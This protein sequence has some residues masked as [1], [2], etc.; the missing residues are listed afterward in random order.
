MLEG[1]ESANAYTRRVA[2][3]RPTAT[4][5]RPPSPTRSAPRTT[6][7]EGVEY[8]ES[9]KPL[10]DAAAAARAEDPA[11]AVLRQHDA[12]ADRRGARHLADARVPAARPDARAAARAACSPRTSSA[13]GV[14][15]SAARL[16]GALRGRER[17]ARDRGRTAG[18]G[19]VTA[20][21]R[22]G[23]PIRA[24]RWCWTASADRQG[25]EQHRDH[26]RAAPAGSRARSARGQ[27]EQGAAE[28]RRSA[29]PSAM[30]TLPASAAAVQHDAT[31]ARH[32]QRDALDA[33]SA[34]AAAGAR[35]RS[36]HRPPRRPTLPGDP[37]VTRGRRTG[38]SVRAPDVRALLVVNPK[39]TTT[40]PRGSRRPRCGRSPASSSV[41]VVETSHRGH[42]AELAVRAVR[43][44]LDVVVALGGDGTVNEVVNGLLDRRPAGGRCRRWRSCPAVD[45]RLRPRA[46]AAD[47]PGRRDR[48]DPR[49][50]ARPGPQADRAR[51][52]PTTATSRSTPASASTPRWC[53]GSR[54][55]AG[56]AR[57]TRTRCS[58]GPRSPSTLTA[59][60]AR[61]RRSPLRAAGRGADATATSSWCHEH[62]PWSYL[63][64]DRSSRAR[65]PPSTPGWTSSRS[66]ACGPSHSA[67]RP[68]GRCCGPR[69]CA[70]ADVLQRHDVDGVHAPREPARWRCSST[71]TA[72]GERSRCASG[73][74]R[75]CSASSSDAA[76]VS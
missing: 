42:A 11:A 75:T 69:R 21:Q 60:R 13:V 6:A 23:R 12:V 57:P 44:G 58:S 4:T 19:T 36:G 63:G 43:E 53:A 65:R 5:G 41:E 71:G 25:D 9:L 27:Q 66:T 14:A 37:A 18:P 62:R 24:G 73:R 45:Q 10:L 32:Q 8:R 74:C 50:A 26:R 61:T 54:S 1:L 52:W 3:R 76:A 48:R 59:D 49:G 46:R 29:R 15:R 17:A 38:A 51:A 2:R 67:L 70:A 22:T 34:A 72:L 7:L 39:A 30:R 20:D 28:D 35:R 16:A 33:T 40:T 68:P 56:P 64:R 47:A 55:G 31:T